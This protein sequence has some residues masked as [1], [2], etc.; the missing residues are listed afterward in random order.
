MYMFN[1]FG[2]YSYKMFPEMFPLWHCDMTC[3]LFVLFKLS[4]DLFA[5][6]LSFNRFKWHIW[7][8]KELTPND[9]R[10]TPEQMKEL[11]NTEGF[12]RMTAYLIGVHRETWLQKC[13]CK[14]GLYEQ[15]HRIQNKGNIHLLYFPVYGMYLE[16]H[17]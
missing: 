5:D 11:E 1:K 12:F 4:A 13:R 6:K 9:Q 16:H 10:R 14:L 17:V 7:W 2:K 8:L 15:K 3:L